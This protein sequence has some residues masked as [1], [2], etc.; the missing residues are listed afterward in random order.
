MQ[1][2]QAGINYALTHNGDIVEHVLCLLKTCRG[3]DIYSELGTNALQVLKQ[4]LVG[5]VLCTVEAHVLQKMRKTILVVLFLECTYICRQIELGTLCRQVVV[6]D[7]IGKS[8][9]KLTYPY[10]RVYR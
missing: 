1:H 9:F 3:I 7:I 8:V 10:I 2:K 6:A 5:E 4:L